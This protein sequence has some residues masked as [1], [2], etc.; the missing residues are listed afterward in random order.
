MA[1]KP[2]KIQK[3]KSIKKEVKDERGNYSGEKARRNRLIIS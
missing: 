1:R 3:K 2:G